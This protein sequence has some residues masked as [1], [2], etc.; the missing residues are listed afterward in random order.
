MAFAYVCHSIERTNINKRELSETD[1]ESTGKGRVQAKTD[2]HLVGQN[3]T[4]SQ[5]GTDLVH[6]RRV[7]VNKTNSTYSHTIV[8][9]CRRVISLGTAQSR[10]EVQSLKITFVG[11]VLPVELGLRIPV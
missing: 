2:L 5:R 1:S 11:V 3:D 7:E 10:E 9:L 6:S 8:H 4:P